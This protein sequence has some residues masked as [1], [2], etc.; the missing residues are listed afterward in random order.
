MS[1]RIR[2]IQMRC[3]A[4]ASS[5]RTGAPDEAR[6]SI[7]TIRNRQP[8]LSDVTCSPSGATRFKVSGVFFEVLRSMY[9]PSKAGERLFSGGQTRVSM[10]ME[11][12]PISPQPCPMRALMERRTRLLVTE[13]ISRRR[14][15]TVSD[16]NIRTTTIWV[17]FGGDALMSQSELNGA[18]RLG[19][20]RPTKSG[21]VG[22]ARAHHT[23][24]DLHLIRTS[25]CLNP[26]RSGTGS[27]R[28][29]HHHPLGC[30]RSAVPRSRS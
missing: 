29:P 1:T 16:T 22:L 11:L 18:R 27:I 23:P 19:S 2:N 13:P 3:A 12:F 26:W 24:P 10:H 15:G 8:R 20:T 6:T 9:A 21:S 17:S 28:I 7:P 30:S 25:V 14:T 5:A 4:A